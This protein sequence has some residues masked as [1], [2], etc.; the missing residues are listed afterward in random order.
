MATNRKVIQMNR[1]QETIKNSIIK[2]HELISRQFYFLHR[3]E[4]NVKGLRKIK[5]I[6]YEKEKTHNDIP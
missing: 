4:S 6:N 3:Q 5:R 1:N 2:S